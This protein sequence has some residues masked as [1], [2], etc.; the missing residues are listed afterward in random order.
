[1]IFIFSSVISVSS[2]SNLSGFSLMTEVTTNGNFPAT[3]SAEIFSCNVSTYAPDGVPSEFLESR[4]VFAPVILG[5]AN[6]IS[7]LFRPVVICPFCTQI[8]R[9]SC[10]KLPTSC[11][12]PFRYRNR[13][14]SYCPCSSYLGRANNIGLPSGLKA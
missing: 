14:L 12:S 7:S 2:T 4:I 1:M 9:I 10:A 6:M 3:I 13:K 11:N 5:S 8:L